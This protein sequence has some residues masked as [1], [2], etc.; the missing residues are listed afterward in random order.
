M[1][2]HMDGMPFSLFSFFFPPSNF[3]FVSSFFF[4]FFS[5]CIEIFDSGK[6]YPNFPNRQ[7][8]VNQVAQGKLTP[9][10]PSTCPDMLVSILEECFVFDANKRL[11]MAEICKRMNG[12]K[13]YAS[14]TQ[15]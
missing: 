4:F 10:I 6:L 15:L 9:P 14:T 11:S 1:Y 5:V 13:L 7:E 12:V 2:G 3:L 8:I